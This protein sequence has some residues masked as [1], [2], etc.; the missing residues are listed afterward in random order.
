MLDGKILKRALEMSQ[1][2]TR[3]QFIAFEL[4]IEYKI[5]KG[6]NLDQNEEKFLILKNDL[7][8]KLGIT[9]DLHAKLRYEL[10]DN[11]QFVLKRD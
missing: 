8:T 1:D 10:R 6:I 11:W 5:D 2:E 3:Q 9:T 4:S 7:A